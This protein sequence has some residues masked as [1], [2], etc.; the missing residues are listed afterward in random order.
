[1]FTT[2]DRRLEDWSR[3][4]VVDAGNTDKDGKR[5]KSQTEEFGTSNKT[6]IRKLDK[7]GIPGTAIDPHQPPVRIQE[8][9]VLDVTTVSQKAD[10]VSRSIR[11][12][13]PGTSRRAGPFAAAA[14]SAAA[15]DGSAIGNNQATDLYVRRLCA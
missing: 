7:N 4:I 2:P 8:Q 12:W 13:L 10:R 5:V 1:M 9:Y 14:R 6:I 11:K 3:V 15:G